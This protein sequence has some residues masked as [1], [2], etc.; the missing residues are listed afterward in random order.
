MT[1][2]A[3]LLAAVHGPVLAVGR[4][5]GIL[6]MALMVVAI[7]VQ[8]FWRY[9][10]DNPLPWPEEAARF[11]ML[12]M[13]GVVAPTAWRRG[14]FVAIDTI[15][16]A[17][18][19]VAG[20]VLTLVLLALAFLVLL[21]SVRI[22]WAEVTGFS[23]RF[24]S[25][26]LYYPTLEGWAKMPRSWMM[27]SLLVGVA[28]LLSVTVELIVRQLVLLLRPDTALPEIAQADPLAAGAE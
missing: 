13:T 8:V 10:L 23:G 6:A 21:V 18:P 17:L 11:L 1:G 16:L 20:G 12:W 15:Q 2:I 28:L 25:S 26:S 5:V 24:K 22:G 27:A 14:G 7:L 19:R 9:G 4:W 3:R